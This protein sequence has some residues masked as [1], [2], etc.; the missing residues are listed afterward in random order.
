MDMIKLILLISFTSLALAQTNATAA[1]IAAPTNATAEA[2]IPY[3]PL[4]DRSG[5]N[6]CRSAVDK[7]AKEGKKVCK[8]SDL[9]EK[10]LI[11]DANDNTD[12]CKG[13]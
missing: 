1:P 8:W 9:V 12:K 11:C 13:N 3:K 10:R 2:P 4:I 7:A 6:E 5:P